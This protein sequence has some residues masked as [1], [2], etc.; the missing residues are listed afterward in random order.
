M[1]FSDLVTRLK[2]DISQFT[3][4]M[5]NVRTQTQRFASNLA[6]A[7]TE[8][9][10]DRMIEGY[11]S[12]NDRLKTVGFS[13]RDIARI[14]SGIVISQT[15]YTATRAIRD[16]TSALW[17]FN[18]SLDYAQVTYAAL[19]NSTSISTDFLETLKQFSVDTIFEYTDLENMSR[20][21]LAYGIEYK[22]LMYIIEGLT[23]IGTMS[24]DSAA[25]ERL[26]VAIGQINAK[27]T[28]KAEEIRQL[29]NAYAPMYDILRDKMGLSDED[30]ANIG[31]LQL[32]AAD[33]INAI[34]E[35]AN[36][37]F[38]PVSD[39]AMLTIT[40]LNNR[41]IDSLK[42]LGS[43]IMKPVTT[44]YK[45]LAKYLSDQLEI[46]S[47]IYS[48]AGLGGVFEHL[49]PDEAWQQRI[50]TFIANI[51]NL[52]A[53]VITWFMSIK[54]YLDLFIGGL[55]DAFNLMLAVLNVVSSAII[56]AL[57]SIGQYTPILGDLTRA[58]IVAGAAWML[59]RLQA[60]ASAVVSGVSAAI[61]GVAKAVVFL[62]SALMSNPIT[63]ML[64]LFGAVFTGLA[65]KADSASSAFSKVVDSLSSFSVGGSTADDILQTGNAMDQA[66][67]D[68]EQFWEAMENGAG[69]AEDFEDAAGGAGKAAKK[70]AKDVRGLLSFDEVF[71]LPEPAAGSAGSGTG[72]GGGAGLGE[73]D[74]SGLTDSLGGLGGA[75]VPEVPDLS[76][77]AS[78][79]VDELSTSLMDAVKAIGSGGMV[80]ALI[81]GLAG[82]AIGA[83]VTKSMAGA[84][85]GAKWGAKLGSLAGAG[86]A[87]FWTTTY[88]EMEGSL[89]KIA[90][91]GATGALVGGLV[92]L[93]VGAFATR[94][95]DGALHAAK[96]GAAIGGLVGA[97]LGGFWASATEEMESAI[98]AIAVGS[99]GG[100]LIGA[101]AGFI[102]GAFSTKTLSGAMLAGLY[103]ASIGSI[104]SGAL[105]GIFSTFTAELQKQIAAITV[106]S[107]EGMLVGAL[108]GFILG[109]YATGQL[110]DAIAGA[111]LGAMIGTVIGGGIGAIFSD[112]E[113]A[114]SE[115]I[116]NMFA[117]V[118]AAS[119]GAVIGGLVGMIIGA[120]VGAFAGGIGALPG[121]KLG[122]TLGAAIGG[123]GA[124]LMTYLQQSG[125]T[126]A[127][128]Q[129]LDGLWTSIVEWFGKVQTDIQLWWDTMITNVVAWLATTWYNI[130]TWWDELIQGIKDW[131]EGIRLA[132]STWWTNLIASIVLWLAT[133]WYNISTWWA[134]LKANVSLWLSN[135]WTNLSTWFSDLISGIVEWLKDI[136]NEIKQWF[137]DLGNDI[138]D[139]W[140][141]LFDHKK[142]TAGWEAV[143]S[144]FDDL[145][146]D[147]GDWFSSLKDK[148][149]S[150][151]S[152]LWS[153][154]KAPSISLPS[155][156]G[157]STRTGGGGNKLAARAN[158]GVFNKE[159]IARF[160]EGNKAEAIIPL[161]NNRAMQPFVD[162]VAGGLLQSL[163]PT[164]LQANNSSNS[165]SGLPPMY[166]GTLIAD[167]RGLKQLSKKLELIQV[168]ENAR[169][170]LAT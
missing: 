101:L 74:L 16:A 26:A 89:Q 44:F 65:T 8:G 127:L 115:A 132:I 15:F 142:W 45:S 63:A 141:N 102:I 93:V 109:A 32:P 30:F 90:V 64:L 42:V 158:G 88:E 107:A 122:A 33:V 152:N 147:I 130:S 139:W 99:A 76:E 108:A 75:L 161:E 160:A 118:Q 12:L 151:W 134:D 58:L 111:R 10:A 17:S 117:D 123:L 25:L 95:V 59:F 82:F 125:I 51:Q 53:N 149:S 96:W 163:A 47:N 39:A 148:I 106:G 11:T 110:K 84:L 46:I 77:W 54:P 31:N 71:K 34:V 119:Y 131:I 83:L 22:N 66:A 62:A 57:Q 73:L 154:L 103:G 104:V 168:Q 116:S 50:R 112:G 14:S 23:N 69:A 56:G 5:G 68:S 100:A 41:I 126:E 2:L 91:G 146:S 52:L 156:G 36:E 24:G 162:A 70:A 9:T 87:A 167:E 27:G 143:K 166:V 98:E 169:R 1:N 136:W 40:G 78:G 124:M 133:T 135:A 60:L 48:E 29:T 157:G 94:S 21:L 28:L 67:T 170:G 105:S 72:S 13:L 120:V 145:W 144:W 150:W 121:A 37:Q 3:R 43:N 80:G 38:G 6:A 4:A 85:T 86:F 153:G 61:V 114:V 92:G 137:T 49:V 7:S 81:G 79:F 97:G 35:Y 138:K 128:A 159:H 19:F 155:L 164:L 140:E 18:E 55:F 113:T 165:T 20:K 129:W